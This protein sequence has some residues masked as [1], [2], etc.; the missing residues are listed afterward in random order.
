MEYSNDGNAS[1]TTLSK[2]KSSRKERKKRRSDDGWGA[3]LA[4]FFHGYAFGETIVGA[5]ATPVMAYLAGL[6]VTILAMTTA[7]AW[8]GRRVVATGAS[9]VLV[10]RAAAGLL[11]AGGAVFTVQA[12]VA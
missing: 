5:E 2:G 11:I 1:T 4:G 7:I 10:H 6:S 9:P 12:L 8:I 3:R